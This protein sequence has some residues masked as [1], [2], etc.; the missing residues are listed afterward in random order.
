MLLYLLLK[1]EDILEFV[2]YSRYFAIAKKVENEKEIEKTSS[3]LFSDEGIDGDLLNTIKEMT[4]RLNAEIDKENSKD[5]DLT[6]D[7]GDEDGDK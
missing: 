4:E 3:D 7:V 6:D 2:D 5:D 1:D